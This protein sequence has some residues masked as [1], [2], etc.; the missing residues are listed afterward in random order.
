M[1]EL[2]L[3][4]QTNFERTAGF[5]AFSTSIAALAKSNAGSHGRSNERHP[6]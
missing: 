6:F 1:S 3:A 4:K 5:H 2:Q